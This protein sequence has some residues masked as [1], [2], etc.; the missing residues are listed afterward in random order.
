MVERAADLNVEAAAG[1]LSD[2]Q[3]LLSGGGPALHLPIEGGQLT[4]HSSGTSSSEMSVS[5]IR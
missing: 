5:S 1:L 3:L 4:E 2:A